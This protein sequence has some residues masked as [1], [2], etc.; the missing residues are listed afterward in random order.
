MIWI[1]IMYYVEF[2]YVYYNVIESALFSTGVNARADARTVPYTKCFSLEFIHQQKFFTKI[3]APSHRILELLA[4]ITY[5]VHQPSIPSGLNS[6]IRDV[7]SLN[8]RIWSIL[9]ENF[10]LQKDRRTDRQ[11]HSNSSL[12]KVCITEKRK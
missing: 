4:I 11:R 3:Y 10:F 7:C 9:Y 12:D 2:H 8:L 5:I 1:Y 6:R